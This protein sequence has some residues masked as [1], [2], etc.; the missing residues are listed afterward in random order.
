MKVA[1][2]TT[3][4]IQYQVPW[5]RMLGQSEGVDLR[6]FF[7]M[8]PD[9]GEQGREFGVAFEW[10]TPLLDGYDYQVLQNVARQPSLTSFGGC[11]TPSVGAALREGRF[12]AVIVNGWGTRMALQALW[13]CRRIGIPCV[14]RGE[15]NGLRP[16]GMARRIGHRL[17]LSQY[18]AFL[19]IGRQNRAYYR[20]LGVDPVQIFDTPYCVDNRKF[21]ADAENARRGASREILRASFGLEPVTPTFVFSGK[22][23]EKKHPL[24][25]VLAL[26]RLLRTGRSA[27]L[28]MV[29]DGPLRSALV[30]ASEGLPV[31]FAGFLNQSRIAAAYVASDCLVLP[32][33]AGET[34]GLV[35]N[36][37]MA[38]GTPAV[39][40]DQVGCAIDLARPGETGEVFPC[41]DVDALAAMMGACVDSADRWAGR[42]QAAKALVERDYCFEQVGNGVLAALNSVA[43]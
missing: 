5:L 16:R 21:A 30:A 39:V 12:D 22:F 38:C 19:A 37:A 2:V 17:L 3:H 28:L 14:V 27:Q 33:D 1:V 15:A 13:A 34:W 4:P 41:R 25:A 20:S 6:V 11:D 32:S 10:D 31:V 29:G 18:A 26:R 43:R 36:E 40:S 7:A 23:V 42:G 8:L 9:A 35:V 24:D